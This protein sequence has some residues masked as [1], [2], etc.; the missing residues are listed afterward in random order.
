MPRCVCS[1]AARETSP[2]CESFPLSL[3]FFMRTSL[4]CSASRATNGSQR[5]FDNG[6]VSRAGNSRSFG[7]CTTS[8]FGSHATSDGSEA[9][10]LDSDS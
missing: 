10:K 1:R 3:L 6:Q 9:D 5:S 2:L 8:A 4:W 7:A